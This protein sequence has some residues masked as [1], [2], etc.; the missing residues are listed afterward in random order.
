MAINYINIGAAGFS[1]AQRGPIDKNS[2][3]ET[4]DQMKS[5]VVNADGT[6]YAG[7]IISLSDDKSDLYKVVKDGNS[8]KCISLFSESASNI[9]KD[10]QSWTK[11]FIDG[12]FGFHDVNRQYGSLYSLTAN[13][14]EAYSSREGNTV[15]VISYI[16]QTGDDIYNKLEALK[17]KVDKELKDLNLFGLFSCQFYNE[18]DG[19]RYPAIN[20]GENAN[21]RLDKI[22]LVRN[23]GNEKGNTYS[24]WIIN[25]IVIDYI[26][27]Q[28]TGT[29]VITADD[30]ERYVNMFKD[31]W[32]GTPGDPLSNYVVHYFDENDQFWYEWEQEHPGQHRT[33]ALLF[34]EH[35][36]KYDPWLLY[37]K[38]GDITVDAEIT[39]IVDD[40]STRLNS[41][42]TKVADYNSGYNSGFY[43]IEFDTNY[44]YGNDQWAGLGYI[45]DHPDEFTDSL[46]D[47]NHL[48][49][50]IDDY[51][52]AGP[53]NK[54]WGFN[55]LMSYFTD[56]SKLNKL[57]LRF[58]VN[59]NDNLSKNVSYIVPNVHLTNDII[60][61]YELSEP[62]IIE[63]IYNSY[64]YKIYLW[65]TFNPSPAMQVE[66]YSLKNSPA[67][68][69][70]SIID[71]DA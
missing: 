7:Q 2:L 12:I 46:D 58:K 60:Y 34:E 14:L 47:G 30:I 10:I 23:G 8:Y 71:L 11:D 64:Y 36:N 22:Y 41:L 33:P 62:Y 31:G 1:K 53:G 4:E 9:T 56:E 52:D 5:F 50:N 27:G 39:D 54:K 70:I 65:L 18:V 17:T 57:S 21:I 25:P 69:E 44:T 42:S 35:L 16:D 43:D 13:D 63:F 3:F 45:I 38:I 59:D 66:K 6:A 28:D 24:E 29:P 15:N 26:L 48:I 61:D 67:D 55:Q 49:T 37:E 40:I 68:Y 51:S 20:W 19:K 32:M